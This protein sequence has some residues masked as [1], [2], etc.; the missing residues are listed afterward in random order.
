MNDYNRNDVETTIEQR[1]FLRP[2]LK[3]IEP[4]NWTQV[5]ITTDIV[6]EGRGLRY[7][8]IRSQIQREIMNGSEKETIKNNYNH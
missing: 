7:D 6:G 8:S 3:N 5:E 1:K 4:N 2:R